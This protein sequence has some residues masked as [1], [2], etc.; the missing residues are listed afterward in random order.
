MRVTALFDCFQQ[1]QNLCFNARGQNL[2]F[3]LDQSWYSSENWKALQCEVFLGC[4]NSLWH[5]LGV[6]SKTL[7]AV[8]QPRLGGRACK[9]CI[10]FD[11]GLLLPTDHPRE[12]DPS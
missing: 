8:L 1:E 10:D 5:C 11:I 9:F 3:F 6:D 4:P 12:V 2:F 7:L